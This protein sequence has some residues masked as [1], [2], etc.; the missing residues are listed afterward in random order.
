MLHLV[1]VKLWL[2]VL[3]VGAESNYPNVA[4]QKLR[5]SPED[6]AEIT[7]SERNCT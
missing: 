1:L 6:E 3:T 2:Y 4:K 7:D 5:N